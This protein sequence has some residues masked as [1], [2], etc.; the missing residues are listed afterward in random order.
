MIIEFSDA[1][2]FEKENKARLKVLTLIIDK[3]RN[4]E[5]LQRRIDE[6]QAQL[7]KMPPFTII[8]ED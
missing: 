1:Q 3:Q 7:R 8:G 5:A 4:I 6:L 2:L